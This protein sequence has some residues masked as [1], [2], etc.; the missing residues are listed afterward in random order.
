MVAESTQPAQPSE[1]GSPRA[2]AA[3]QMQ[4]LAPL[5]EHGST[6]PIPSERQ[7]FGRSRE[8]LRMPHLIEVQLRSFEWFRREGLR[9]LFA[10]ISPI[11][12]FT[13]KN[14]ELELAVGAEP[15][16]APKWAPGRVPRPGHDLR[17]AAVLRGAAAEQADPGDQGVAHLHGRLPGDDG[18]R[19]VHRQRGGAGGGLPAGALAGGLLHGGG[20]PG[21][22]APAVRGQAD[23]QPGGLAGVRDQRQGPA[24][25]QG[26]PQ[27][28]AAGDHPAAGPGPGVRHRRG[29]P[30]AVRRR[31]HRPRAALH[32]GDHRAGRGRPAGPGALAR[33][34][35][36]G[37]VPAPAPGRPGHPGERPQ[38]GAE[39]VLQPPALRPGARGALQAEQAPARWWGARSAP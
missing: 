35:A 18:A 28:Q 7:W 19:D 39:P 34:G 30:G 25:G 36:A 37:G 32:R 38:P 9:E 11:A 33:G 1:P 22:G 15:F 4:W 27:A 2:G 3:E 8:L 13:G 17:R 5:E 31:R 21:H 26:G 14:L 20:G 12:D 23:P 16:G 6:D 29:A 24:D 10:E